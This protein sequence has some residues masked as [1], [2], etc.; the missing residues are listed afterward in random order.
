[1]RAELFDASGRRVR[2][3]AAAESYPSGWHDVAVDGRDD[4]ASMLSAGIYF[5]RIVSV[6]G[7]VTGRLVLLR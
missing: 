6:D 3:L 7:V 4:G 5:Y 2:R 1:M